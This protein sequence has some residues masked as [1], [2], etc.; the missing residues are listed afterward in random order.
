MKWL[1]EDWRHLWVSWFMLS[2]DSPNG[3]HE[4]DENFRPTQRGE[5]AM[6]SQDSVPGPEQDCVHALHE[7]RDSKRSHGLNCSQSITHADLEK[8]MDHLNAS[9]KEDLS[10]DLSVAMH[11]ALEELKKPDEPPWEY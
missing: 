11:A 6:T 7:R 5:E 3:H 1:L 10:K 8:T 4:V 9:I 2:T